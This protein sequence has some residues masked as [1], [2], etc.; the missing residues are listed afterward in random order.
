MIY[1]SVVIGE[2]PDDINRK[3]IV[4]WG[5]DNW[6]MLHADTMVATSLSDCKSSAA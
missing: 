3:A 5:R 2:G 4:A 6:L 1:F